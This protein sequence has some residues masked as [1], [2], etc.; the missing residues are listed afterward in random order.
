MRGL[1]HS[2][3]PATIV[4]HRD[5]ELDALIQQQA[6]ELDSTKRHELMIQIQWHI[7]D[8]AYMF[9]PVMVSSQWMFD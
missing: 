4:G 9:S 6:S 5:D 8:Q 1:L 2:G 3:G 7:L